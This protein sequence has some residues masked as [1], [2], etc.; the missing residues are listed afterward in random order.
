MA[1]ELLSFISMSQLFTVSCFGKLRPCIF[2]IIFEKKKFIIHS[3]GSY[4]SI[5]FSRD[6]RGFFFYPMEF[7]KITMSNSL[8]ISKIFTNRF[9]FSCRWVLFK[10]I[11]NE[12]IFK[13]ITV[14][15]EIN[16]FIYLFYLSINFFILNGVF[17]IYRLCVV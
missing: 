11:W 4:Y 5:F 3:L 13:I 10:T 2:E 14:Q 12:I 6:S 15:V 9:L 8:N 16:V 7:G 17:A 1:W